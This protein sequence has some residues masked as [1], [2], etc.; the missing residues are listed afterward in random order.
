M[1]MDS[2]LAQEIAE[3]VSPEVIRGLITEGLMKTTDAYS[4]TEAIKEIAQPMILAECKRYMATKEFRAKLKR[5]V[6]QRVAALI[7]PSV[8]GTLGRLAEQMA[9]M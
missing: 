2:K 9:K 7:E 8:R 5:C 1:I 6:S 3:A 4:T